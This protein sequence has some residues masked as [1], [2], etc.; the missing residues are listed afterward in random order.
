[1]HQIGLKDIRSLEALAW[2]SKVRMYFKFQHLIVN[3]HALLR[4]ALDFV[5]ICDVSGDYTLH[6]WDWAPVAHT[7]YKTVH[8]DSSHPTF[9]LGEE[10]RAL[11]DG[12]GKVQARAYH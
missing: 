10:I 11:S 6:W 9:P 3:S 4:R 2:A 7:L 12:Q 5:R 8:P 1:M